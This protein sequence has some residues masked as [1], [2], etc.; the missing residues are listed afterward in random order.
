[1]TGYNRDSVVAICIRSNPKYPDYAVNEVMFEDSDPI[2]QVTMAIY[3][4]RTHVEY[5]YDTL[6]DDYTLWSTEKMG[7]TAVQQLVGELRPGYQR[8]FP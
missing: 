5:E 3:H 4:G 8:G 7:F 1:M 6:F 2:G